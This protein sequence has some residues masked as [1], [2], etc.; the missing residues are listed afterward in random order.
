M[1][2]GE[3][4][5]D[6]SRVP[7]RALGAKKRSSFVRRMLICMHELLLKCER[8]RY[9]VHHLSEEV[10]LWP[11]ERV[12]GISRALSQAAPHHIVHALSHDLLKKEKSRVLSHTYA[13]AYAS[14]LQHS[15][16]VYN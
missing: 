10:A 11:D 14:T 13:Y 2:E 6:Y 1:K 4:R 9:S 5:H 7:Y 16:S 15:S 3:R 12:S 8:E